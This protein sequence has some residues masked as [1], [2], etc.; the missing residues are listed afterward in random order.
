[1]D[2]ILSKPVGLVHVY[3]PGFAGHRHY[4]KFDS[5]LRV[6]LANNTEELCSKE[7]FCKKDRDIQYA[8]DKIEGIIDML[9]KSVS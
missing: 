4:Y 2:E 6:G 1:M 9:I 3:Q 5:I 7:Y 8:R